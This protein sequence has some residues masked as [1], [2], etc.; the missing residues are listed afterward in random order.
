MIIHHN[1]MRNQTWNRRS[2]PPKTHMCP[3]HPEPCFGSPH[4]SSSRRLNTQNTMIQHITVYCIQT[5][6]KNRLQEKK[7]GNKT[8]K[9]RGIYDERAGSPLK[10]CNPLA[11]W[12]DTLSCF[13]T[14]MLLEPPA[15]QCSRRLGGITD[16]TL[17][18]IWR[19]FA[20]VAEHLSSPFSLSP[21]SSPI[22]HLPFS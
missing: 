6:M 19:V 13:Q 12:V 4:R 18:F 16:L 11:G 10:E 3:H 9:M 21:S 1:T 20:V 22:P 8:V 15:C 5:C 17:L 14:E 7:G 2:I